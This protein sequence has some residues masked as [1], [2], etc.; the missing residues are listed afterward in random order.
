MWHSGSG[1]RDVYE[2]FLLGNLKE[3]DYLG[4][5]GIDGRII[6]KLI[7]KTGWVGVWAGLILSQEW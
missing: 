3:R 1:G 5:L 6:S 7:T 4:D 2:A